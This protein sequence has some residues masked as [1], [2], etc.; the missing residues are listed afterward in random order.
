MR[1]VKAGNLKGKQIT[2]KIMVRSANAPEETAKF[3]GHGLC[4]SHSKGCTLSMST[5]DKSVIKRE[6]LLLMKMLKADP[7]N[8]RGIGIQVSKLEKPRF[9]DLKGQNKSIMN[10]MSK[11]KS[12][13]TKSKTSTIA[14]PGKALDSKVY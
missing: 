7:K 6:T 1:M 5:N 10:F 3:L 2:L 11:K 13:S 12:S 14:S 8:L 9:Q 4:D